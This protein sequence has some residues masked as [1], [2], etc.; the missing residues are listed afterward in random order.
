[1]LSYN[2]IHTLADINFN[3]GMNKVCSNDPFTAY[4][5]SI[6]SVANAKM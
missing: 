5:N 3:S 6:A 4:L 2:H 1:M